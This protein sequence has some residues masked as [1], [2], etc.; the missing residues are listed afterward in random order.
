MIEVIGD[1]GRRRRYDPNLA[2]KV[3]RE[4]KE[5]KLTPNVQ[6]TVD[7]DIEK[8][9]R[10]YEGFMK[11]DRDK[12]F[13][14]SEGESVIPTKITDKFRPTK[15]QILKFSKI[16]VKYKDLDKFNDTVNYLTAL[17]H[18]SEDDEFLI[19][20]TKL[21]E[22]GVLLNYVGYGLEN[23]KLTVN[24]DVGACFGMCA[25]DCK[26]IANKNAG[27]DFGHA[28]IECEIYVKGDIKNISDNIGEGT[29]IYQ[30]KEGEWKQIYPK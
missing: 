20:L 19:D 16:L 23:K 13:M 29:R 7:A 15:N 22:A 3:N 21:S 12:E 4:F 30:E 6:L 27:R 26:I 17:M 28:S 1:R 8:I 24:G 25:Q 10:G 2:E 9:C 5:G 14:R 11:L 18:S